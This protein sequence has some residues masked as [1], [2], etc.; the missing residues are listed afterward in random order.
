MVDY[1]TDSTT[2]WSP[3][4]CALCNVTLQFI[5]RWSLFPH[6]LNLGWA[7]DLLGLVECHGND[8]APIM[9]LS[10]KK[11]CMFLFLNF[12]HATKMTLG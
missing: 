2:W 4:V 12:C 7:C 1:C 11:P 9:N 10:F 5:K 6:L 3:C 8:V